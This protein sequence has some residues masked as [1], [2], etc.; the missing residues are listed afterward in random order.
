MSKLSLVALVGAL[1]A[2]PAN[3][4]LT[5]DN[6]VHPRYAAGTCEYHGYRLEISCDLSLP[7]P[8]RCQINAAYNLQG[9]K[10]S[11]SFDTLPKPE[12]VIQPPII[13]YC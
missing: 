6:L 11:F 5:E 9:K 2:Q 13:L 12:V 4:L 10:V 3:A 1:L 8:P 7:A